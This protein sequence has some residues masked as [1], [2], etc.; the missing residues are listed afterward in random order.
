MIINFAAHLWFVRNLF[1]QVPLE[2]EGYSIQT[3]AWEMSL[4]LVRRRPIQAVWIQS[5]KIVSKSIYKFYIYPVFRP[6]Y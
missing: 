6:S 5:L 1:K 2:C 4:M 3:K